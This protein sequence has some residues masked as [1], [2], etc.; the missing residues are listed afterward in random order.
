MLSLTELDFKLVT[1]D[2]NGKL[3]TTESLDC[4]NVKT[5]HMLAQIIVQSLTTSINSDGTKNDETA[6]DIN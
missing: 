3:F 1:L 6:P 2:S 4:L 5:Y